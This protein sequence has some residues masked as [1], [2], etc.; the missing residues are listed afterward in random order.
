METHNE[1]GRESWDVICERVRKRLPQM[2]HTF[3]Q[4]CEGT[5][6]GSVLTI[7]GDSVAIGRIDNERVRQAL[8]DESGVKRVVFEAERG[9][10]KD[11]LSKARDRIAK[12]EADVN[13]YG[14]LLRDRET[15]LSMYREESEKRLYE[16]MELR[17]KV[18]AYEKAIDCV[19]AFG[20]K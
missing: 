10:M 7:Y 5:F 4:E 18:A 3:L 16:L 6:C 11:K 2:Y 15:A 20:G 19:R 13:E 12:L 9:E 8:L 14:E 1:P 17:G